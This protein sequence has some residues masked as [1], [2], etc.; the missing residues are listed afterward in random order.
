MS[1]RPRTPPRLV[2]RTLATTFATVA[3]VLA[4]TFIVMTL[5]VRDRVRSWVVSNLA[6]TQ[7]LFSIVERNRQREMQERVTTLAG[8]ADLRATVDGYRF[9]SSTRF[10]SPQNQREWAGG[11]HRQVQQIAAASDADVV[12]VADPR[13]VTLATAGTFGWAWPVGSEIQVHGIADSG[14]G[15]DGIVKVP[16]GVFRVAVAPLKLAG[17][18]V[19]RLYL[20]NSLDQKYALELQRLTRA[21]TAIVVGGQIV[22]STLP[23]PS[24]GDLG[25]LGGGQ[26]DGVIVLQGEEYAFSKFFEMGDTGYYALA[27]ID[28]ASARAMTTTLQVMTSIGLGAMVLAA[29]A[30]FWLARTLSRPIDRLSASMVQAS[31]GEFDVQLVACGSS[32]EVDELVHTFNGLMSS[33]VTARAQAQEAYIGSIRALAMMLDARDRYTA[34]HSERVAMLAVSIGRQMGLGTSDLDQLRLGALLHDIGKVGLSDDVLRKPG[35]LTHEEFELIKAHP[36]LGARILKMVPSLAPVLPIVEL[37][38]ERL[39]G[40]GYPHGLRGEEIPLFA[41]IVHCADAYDAMTTARAYRPAGSS[42]H[43]L[44]EIWEGR[45][46][47][48]DPAVVDALIQSL[49]SA[50]MPDA[51]SEPSEPVAVSGGT[52]V[53]MPPTTGS[54]GTRARTPRRSSRAPGF[55]Q[56]PRD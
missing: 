4:I 11:I 36:V 43:A 29:L 35:R 23:Q 31:R 13:N 14:A 18:T 5:E 1:S 27:S 48:F 52:V 40:Q 41:R 30:S 6:S 12:A 39:D 34:G 17:M 16:G 28:A 42:S 54:D 7:E 32:Q 44:E 51:T 19:G 25:G 55:G 38:H 50:A 15:S 49:P 20:A 33:L 37:H 47:D 56:D 3:T 53:W 22:A 2:W 26:T 10:P 45:G 46:V 9:Q 8:A 21:E 24:Q